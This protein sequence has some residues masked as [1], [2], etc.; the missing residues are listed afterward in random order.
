MILMIPMKCSFLYY[1]NHRPLLTIILMSMVLISA[2]AG[3]LVSTMLIGS[4]NRR[5]NIIVA[6]GQM[7]EKFYA[8]DSVEVKNVTL[9]LKSL[10][11]FTLICYIL[12]FMFIR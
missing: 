10:S 5:P 8:P 9:M 3:C 2:M 11:F 7:R 4:E 6:N 12:A 1:P